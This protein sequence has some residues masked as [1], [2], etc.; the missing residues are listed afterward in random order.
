MSYV[1]PSRNEDRALSFYASL[2]RLFALRKPGHEPG[3]ERTVADMARTCL[4]SP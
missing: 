2:W 1:A 3:R 4:R